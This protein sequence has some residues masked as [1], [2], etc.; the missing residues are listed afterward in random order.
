MAEVRSQPPLFALP[1]CVVRVPWNHIVAA[2]T[3][4]KRKMA[5]SRTNSAGRGRFD[6]PKQKRLH[7]VCMCVILRTYNAE[8]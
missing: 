5:A 8:R 2:S 7:F 3:S 1:V 6:T 4:W